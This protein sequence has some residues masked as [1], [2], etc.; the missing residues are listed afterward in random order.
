MHSSRRP[1]REPAREVLVLPAARHAPLF[2]TLE[3]QLLA[4]GV[5]LLAHAAKR[6]A[7]HVW[8]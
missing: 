4:Q 6:V 2:V 8:G 7:F 1:G 3:A 5:V